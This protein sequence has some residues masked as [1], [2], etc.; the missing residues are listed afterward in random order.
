MFQHL[1]RRDI[2]DGHNESLILPMVSLALLL[3]WGVVWWSG[4][5]EAREARIPDGEPPI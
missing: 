4:L 1:P 3:Q 2:C 5:P